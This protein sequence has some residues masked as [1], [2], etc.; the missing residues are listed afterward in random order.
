VFVVGAVVWV[1]FVYV[2]R[3]TTAVDRRLAAWQRGFAVPAAYR[4]PP[5]RGFVSLLKAVTT[6][7][8]TWRDAAWL[9][10]TSVIGPVLGLVGVVS[11]AVAGEFISIPIRYWAAGPVPGYGPLHT[12]AVDTASKALLAGA[13][14]VAL[15]PLTILVARACAAGH[16]GLA[17]RVLAPPAATVPVISRSPNPALIG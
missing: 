9:T 13:V 4:R 7:R 3:A 16:S 2:M 10:V 12:L 8:Q 6:D 14:G 11:V 1:A 5:G 15:L 17:G